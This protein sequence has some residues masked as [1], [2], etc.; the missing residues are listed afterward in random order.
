MIIESASFLTGKSEP[1]DVRRP[2]KRRMI[3]EKSD[4]IF[5]HLIIMPMTLVYCCV[6]NKT[7]KW[8]LHSFFSDNKRISRGSHVAHLPKRQ[9]RLTKLKNRNHLR[10]PHVAYYKASKFILNAGWSIVQAPKSLSVYLFLWP[11]FI[12]HFNVSKIREKILRK[13]IFSFY[14]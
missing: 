11:N 9:T 5:L 6:I 2:K 3:H 13:N 12:S 14:L 8:K 7:A 10:W 1:F 4:H